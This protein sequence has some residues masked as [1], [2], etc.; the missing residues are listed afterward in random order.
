M[1]VQCWEDDGEEGLAVVTDQT[2][3][4]VIAPVVESPF[5]NLRI[6]IEGGRG[7]SYKHIPLK[8]M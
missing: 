6:E 2:H 7:Q 3:D 8:Y 1:L 4:V 5:G